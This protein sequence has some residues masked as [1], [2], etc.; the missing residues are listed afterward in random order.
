VGKP[1]R[2]RALGRSRCRY[3]NNIKMDLRKIGW[4]GLI[5]FRIGTD[6]GVL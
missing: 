1:E 6:G 2:K 3:V 4:I 5:W